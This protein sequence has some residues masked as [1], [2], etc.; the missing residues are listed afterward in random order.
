MKTCDNCGKANEDD[1]LLCLGCG[2]R[3]P[4]SQRGAET[5]SPVSQRPR[6]NARLATMILAAVLGVQLITGL[7]VMVV[8][9]VTFKAQGHDLADTK[10]FRRLTRTVAEPIVALATVSGGL[11]MLFMS[12]SLIREQLF[13]ASPAGA[14]WIIG[15]PKRIVQGVG[16]GV[17][18]GVCYAV[19]AIPWMGIF[20]PHRRAAATPVLLQS[21]MVFTA[22]VLAPSAEEPL[23][24]G[25]LYGGYRRSFGPLW[26]AVLTT[27]MFCILHVGQVVQF[28]PS[29][30]ATA[31]M[32]LAAL[33]FRLRS[34][35]IGPAIAVHF[36]HNATV[37]ALLAISSR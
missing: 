33:W 4:A 2:T 23:F 10:Q 34:A 11:A 8:G 9:I 35:A 24:R 7:L 20:G 28:P 13:D 36:G 21:L 30:V 12:R 14:A 31:S 27:V 19:A 22:L 18:T 25:L 3:L 6:L 16:I 26:A 17:F 5:A 37:L 15:S 29:I 32:A 1:S